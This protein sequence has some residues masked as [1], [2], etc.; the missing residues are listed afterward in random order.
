MN[1]DRLPELRYRIG[2]LAF[3][4][5]GLS[6]LS[7]SSAVSQDCLSESFSVSLSLWHLCVDEDPNR[8][9]IEIVGLYSLHKRAWVAVLVTGELGQFGIESATRLVGGQIERVKEYRFSE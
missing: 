9:G 1:R 7:S 5:F 6:C 4:E 2:D 3:L 8:I